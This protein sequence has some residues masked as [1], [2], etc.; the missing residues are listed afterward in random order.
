M[1]QTPLNTFPP[2]T[3]L[4]KLL[5]NPRNYHHSIMSLTRSHSQ[6]PRGIPLSFADMR[7]PWPG[8]ILMP[9]L[10]HGGILFVSSGSVA[11]A[12]INRNER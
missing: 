8:R 7:N 1:Y 2:P 6:W 12:R 9:P 4:T 10:V 11:T 3:F 5:F